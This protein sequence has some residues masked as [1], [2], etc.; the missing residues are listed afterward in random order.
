MIFK[1]FLCLALCLAMLLT[2]TACRQNDSNLSSLGF[3][4]LPSSLQSEEAL[5]SDDSQSTDTESEKTTTSEDQSKPQSKPTVSSEVQSDESPVPS[6]KDNPSSRPSSS[7]EN[8]EKDEVSSNEETN[9][10]SDAS[11][12]ESIDLEA[13]YGFKSIKNATWSRKKSI[14]N[15]DILYEIDEVLTEK[16]Q[17]ILLYC[18]ILCNKKE[19][20]IN[21]NK[22]TIPYSFCQKNDS[23][24]LT[25]RHRF[26][27]L[28]YNFEIDIKADQWDLS[29]EEE[30]EG[31][32]L[33][34]D[35][36]GEI[37][38]TDNEYEWRENFSYAYKKDAV[39]LDGKGNLINRVTA[40]KEKNSAG[41]PIYTAS[42]ISTKDCF[43]SKYG[44]YE[45][46]AIP[47]RETGMW[48]A[49][50]ILAG[51]MDALDA[52]EDH[53][54]ANGIEIDIFETLYGNKT[55]RHALF[56][57][58]YYNNQTKKD[59][60]GGNE[61]PNL[62]DGKYHTFGLQWTP[63]EFIFFV[64]GNETWRSAAAGGCQEPGHLLISSHIN[65]DIDDVSLQPGEYSDMIVD[66]VRI[67]TND[68]YDE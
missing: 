28:E 38:E 27:G 15:H 4:S 1:R 62:F 24:K 61:I 53:S 39:F 57:D 7:E 66:Y 20:K 41:N 2:V 26:S 36:W 13:T 14:P 5:E 30:F 37:W 43:E 31:D 54:S 51:D 32:T 25:A 52:V 55:A 16:N 63:E 58:G 44:Y 18:D 11:S 65:T 9:D 68:I 59:V 42:L 67:Y 56:W 60:F 35:L 40:L 19:I 3:S 8:S 64:D 17:D 12:T 21:A 50:W 22:I 49:F 6:D 10:N 23:L 45:M 34:T 29:F 33:N 46:R 47:H 48:G